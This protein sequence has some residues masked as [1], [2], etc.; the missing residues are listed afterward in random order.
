MLSISFGQIK[1]LHKSFTPFPKEIS[2]KY[3]TVMLTCFL[4]NQTELKLEKSD[5]QTL[6]IRS[7]WKRE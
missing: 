1:C 6:E 5:T 2:N 4:G 3:N 7:S